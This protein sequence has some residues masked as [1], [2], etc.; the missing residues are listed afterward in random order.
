MI[1]RAVHG[2]RTVDQAPSCFPA[3]WN[4]AKLA[5]IPA[6]GNQ[7]LAG[8][9]DCV[10]INENT[11]NQPDPA[12][13]P[14]N[15]QPMT[16]TPQQPPAEPASESAPAEVLEKL[17]ALPSKPGCYLFRDRQGAV[18]YV[19]KAKSLRSRVRSYFA[20]SQNDERAYMPWLLKNIG[21]LST[22]VTAT[23][24]EAAILEDSLIKEHRPKYNVKLRDDKSYLS[25]RLAS[26]HQWPRLELVRRPSV[27]G[28]RY[29]GPYPSATAARRTLHLVEKHFR[30]RTCSDRELISRKRPCIQHQIGR[31]PAPCVFAVDPEIYAA[32]VRSVS[33]FLD[34]RHDAL[35]ENLSDRMRSASVAMDFELAAV[36]RDQLK[37]INALR[38]SQRVVAVSDADQDVVGL[39]RQQDRIELVVMLVRSGRVVDVSAFSLLRVDVQDDEIVAAFLR[40]RY[41]S[42]GPVQVNLPDEILVPVLPEGAEGISEWFSELQQEAGQRKRCRIVLP[43][44]GAKRQLLELAQE[45]AKHAF[46]EKKRAAEDVQVRLARLQRKL[47]LQVLPRRIECVDISHL[48]GNDTVGAVVALR[49][50][51]PD[52]SRYRT[53]HVHTV[54]GGD[55]YGAILEVL[56]RRFRRGAE[57]AAAAGPVAV[58]ESVAESVAVAD[59]EAVTEAEADTVAEADAVAEAAAVA[60]A[61]AVA[62]SDPDTVEN[63][64]QLPDL[65][66]IDGGRG[67]LAIAL[68]AASDLGIDNLAIVGLAKEKEN[69]QGEKLVD[70][71][72]LPGQK[73]AIALRSGSPEL[74][75]LARARDEA[76]R[77]SNRGRSR[78]G[79]A[80]RLASLLDPIAGVGPKTKKA[81]FATFDSLEKM[82]AA[83]DEDLLQVPGVTATVLAGLRQLFA[84]LEGESLEEEASGD[85]ELPNDEE[86]N[87]NQLGAVPDFS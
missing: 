87:S 25:L 70:R 16:D 43:V 7:R 86:A 22:I 50:G 62:E 39:Y 13:N 64:W 24:K 83:S 26:T 42:S 17:E 41:A 38:E 5:K 69:V 3:S 37:A 18:I 29:F 31:C 72:Y 35:T 81:L 80:R 57:A 12:D 77:F 19:G 49:D 9:S 10:Q 34:G 44:R 6:T 21:D 40:E 47:R 14:F 75:F 55:D 1:E 20:A 71:V 66:V 27:D 78:L 33:L 11:S 61:D 36:L 32:E 28:A 82:Q 56:R 76:H 8:F 79:K 48:G 58:A 51:V 52:K 30:L 73:N 63:A 53:Y 65:F 84:E 74:Y 60:E 15:P 59:A 85:A 4:E 67:Q 2:L 68:T 23:E 54:S 46:E 45:N